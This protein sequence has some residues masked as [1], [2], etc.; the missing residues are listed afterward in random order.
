VYWPPVSTG[1]VA[2]KVTPRLPWSGNLGDRLVSDQAAVPPRRLQVDSG[3]DDAK[4]R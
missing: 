4:A 3:S 1:F 2:Q